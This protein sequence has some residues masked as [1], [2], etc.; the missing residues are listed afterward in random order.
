[1]SNVWAPEVRGQPLSLRLALVLSVAVLGVLLITGIAVN[2][3]VSGSLE[4]ELSAAERDRITVVAGAIGDVDLAVPRARRGVELVLRRV[5]NTM[6]GRAQVVAADGAVLIDVGQP[7]AGLASETIEE[8]I[9]GSDARLLLQ[10]PRADRAFLRIFNLTLLVAGLLAI[11]AVAAIALLLAARLTQPLRGVA[12]AA[13]RLGHGDLSARA[14]GGPDRESSELA[15]AFNAMAARVQRSEMLRRRAASDMAHDLA[16]PATV[17]ESQLQAMVD[18]VVPADREQLDRARAAAGALSGVIVQLGELVDAESG[19]LQRRPVA[20]LLSDLL[21]EVRSAMEPLFRSRSVGLAVDEVPPA[22]RVEVDPTQVGRA[23]RNVLGNAVQ[24]SPDGATVQVSVEAMAAEVIVRVTDRGP[25]IAAQDLPH[26][27]ERFYRADEARGA[28]EPR[29]GSGIGLTIA[30]ELLAAN[31]G[32][33]AVERTDAGGTTF[34]I[35]LP[36]AA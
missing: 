1:M 26:V 11:L 2:R 22:V 5:A 9:P 24:H 21:A 17:L 19:V 31:G 35:G 13:Q 16:T 23:L 14:L 27:F 20:L 29:S 7:P 33:I 8:P 32:R 4:Q 10:V 3:V 30:R 28:G 6:R 18:G 25:G 34:A 12:A 36:R 15:G